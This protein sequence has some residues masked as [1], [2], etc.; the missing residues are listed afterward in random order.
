MTTK[1][2]YQNLAEALLK[3]KLRATH[4]ENKRE[5]IRPVGHQ[6]VTGDG[7]QPTLRA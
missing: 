4:T 3:G 2:A 1:I 7:G 6:G 5:G